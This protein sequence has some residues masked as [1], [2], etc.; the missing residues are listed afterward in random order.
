M[1]SFPLITEGAAP[2]RN[3]T[4]YNVVSPEFFSTVGVPIVRG[5]A[6]TMADRE[7]S[8]PVA[9][10]NQELARRFWPNQEPV[11]KSIR[12]RAGATPFAVVGVAP[13]MEDAQG[14]FSTVR[15]TVYVSEGQGALFLKGTRT[16]VPPYQL[17]LLIRSSG[18]PAPVKAALRQELLARDP[19]LRV[20]IRT[21]DEIRDAAVG[22]FRTIS[23]LLS[24]L[25]AL[26]LVMASVGIYAILA[27][28]VS[29][30]TREIGLRMALGAQR[31]E[32]LSLVMQR[33]VTLIV[34]GIALG[35]AGAIALTRIMG[36]TVEHMGGLDA[37]TCV[38]VA[39]LLGA[40]KLCWPA[41][42]PRAKPCA[43]TPCRRCAGSKEVRLL[44]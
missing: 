35:I 31:R 12:L 14:P 21:A 26:A 2:G 6:L 44:P 10:V 20:A 18:D 28:S 30:R 15:P 9:L 11:G 38:V 32:V 5:R 27:Y 24:A 40:G 29:Q 7:G 42:C 8:Q 23:L 4:D 1:G 22:P 41:T 34:W 25:G 16:D 3:F 36:S 33:T 13:D 19:S 37:P 43:W 39:L 17:Q